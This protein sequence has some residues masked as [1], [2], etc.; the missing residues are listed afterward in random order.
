MVPFFPHAVEI[1]HIKKVH[2]SQDEKDN[3]QFSGN[4]FDSVDQSFRWCS[5]TQEQQDES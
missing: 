1:E 2:A 4:V 5:E 3:A